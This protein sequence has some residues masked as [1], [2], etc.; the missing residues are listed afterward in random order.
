MGLAHL[1]AGDVEQAVDEL[2]A[3]VRA[4][5]G[6]AGLA[7]ALAEALER[8]TAPISAS[9]LEDEGGFGRDAGAQRLD[10][11][12]RAASTAPS[13]S[14]PAHPPSDFTAR[15]DAAWEAAR[16]DLAASDTF[17][18]GVDTGAEPVPHPEWAARLGPD[19]AFGAESARMRRE[20]ASVAEAAA[21]AEAAG[22]GELPSAQAAY[23]PMTSGDPAPP[24]QDPAPLRDAA[25]MRT[26]TAPT[27]TV[28]QAE[29]S[30]I[31]KMATTRLD[32]PGPAAMPPSYPVE[33]R[34]V[35]Q[36]TT[37]PTEEPAP[38][39]EPPAARIE[40]PEIPEPA[41][42][43]VPEPPRPVAAEPPRHVAA[44]PPALQPDIASLRPAPA[45]GAPAVE[46]RTVLIS[47][48]PGKRASWTGR[49]RKATLAG[50][51]FATAITL[52]MG[53]VST[54]RAMRTDV[55]DVGRRTLAV[56]PAPD[57]SEAVAP[58]VTVPVAAPEPSRPAPPSAD[59][60]VRKP[61]RKAVAKPAADSLAASE[62]TLSEPPAEPSAHLPASGPSYA[63]MDRLGVPVPPGG[64][65][66][67]ENSDTR[68]VLAAGG[69][70]RDDAFT[71]TFRTPAAV[72]EIVGFYGS[73]GINGFQPHTVIM[74]GRF[75]GVQR[76]VARATTSAAG[77]RGARITISNPGVDIAAM[78]LVAETTIKIEIF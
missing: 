58:E 4:Y 35:A 29:R 56:A 46:Q 33:P 74:G 66:D 22:M 78:R 72:E 52:A 12:P 16:R 21:R 41:A 9:D 67:A 43:P 8:F 57:P 38:I 2:M 45:A 32:E 76:T 48:E 1:R 54:Y 18:P 59:R 64:I 70:R 69:R 44:E 75:Q 50:A 27:A 24:R 30:A 13:T 42:L 60:E 53:A 17:G 49:T 7:A 31:A 51:T 40:Q 28:G 39:A 73:A 26:S 3:A 61:R 68:Q 77:G 55:A 62:P 6:D 25:P 71:L 65:L 15:Q 34:A 36:E 37:A 47:G 10:G 5:P 23:P 14:R 20:A 11:P 19:D 63:F